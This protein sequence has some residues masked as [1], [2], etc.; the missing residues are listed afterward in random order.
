MKQR[1]STGKRVPYVLDREVYQY[2]DAYKAV[3]RP[4]IKLVL[5]VGVNYNF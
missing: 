3:G 4:K 5:I 2:G 1:Q